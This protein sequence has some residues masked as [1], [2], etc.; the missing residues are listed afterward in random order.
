M[1]PEEGGTL[2]RKEAVGALGGGRESR[3]LGFGKAAVSSFQLT[4][5]CA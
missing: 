1:T 3:S 2:G 4:V 5:A